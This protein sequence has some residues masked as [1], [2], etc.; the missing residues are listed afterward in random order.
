MPL[1]PGTLYEQAGAA[2]ERAVAQFKSKEPIAATCPVCEQ[3]ISVVYRE[4]PSDSFVTKCECHRS[5]RIL[6]G[7]L[8]P[9]DWVLTKRDY[10]LKK[11]TGLGV[12]DATFYA[13]YFTDCHSGLYFD[14][15]IDPRALS[16]GA[17]EEVI[18]DAVRRSKLLYH[19]QRARVGASFF[20]YPGEPLTYEEAVQQLRR[21]NP[22]F[23]ED[24]Y[25]IV[26]S[27]DIR[28]MR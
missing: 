13:M 19:G 1:D 2:A 22:G 25:N 9:P 15:P 17:S 24:V 7:V 27:D 23:C 11:A 16:P 6:R 21:E 10:Y 3:P 26:I 4:P 14:C 28:A 20:K 18:A 12:L 8:G 5:N